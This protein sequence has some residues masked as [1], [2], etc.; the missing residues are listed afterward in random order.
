MTAFVGGATTALAD[1]TTTPTLTGEGLAGVVPALKN[2]QLTPDAAPWRLQA[3]TRVV[4]VEGDSVDLSAEAA[5]F[6]RDLDE[7]SELLTAPPQV[8]T[9]AAGTHAATDI[10]LKSGAVAGTDKADAYQ[11]Q[12]DASGVSITGADKHAVFLGT[13]TVLQSIISAGGLQAATVTDWP[14]YATRSLHVDA[15]RKYFSPQWFKDQ[16]KRMSLLKLTEL[17]YHFS[18][19]EGFRLQTEMYP[20]V[21]SEE[22][23]T[24]AELAEILAVAREYHI[25]VIPAMDI[26]GHMGKVLEAHPEW[27]AGNDN[28]GRRVLDYSKPEV[29]KF[30]TDLIDEFAPLFPTDK[31]HIGGDEVFDPDRLASLGRSFP[32]LQAYATENVG[33][34]ASVMD[35]YMHYLSTV[36]S[37]LNNNGKSRVRAW[38]DALYVGDQ[39]SL[40]ADVEVTYWTKWH[41]TMPSVAKLVEKGHKLINYHDGFFYYV[42]PRCPTCAYNQRVPASAIYDNWLPVNFSGNQTAPADSVLGSSYAIWADKPDLETEE[43]IANGIRLPL[44]AMAERVYAGEQSQVPYSVWEHRINVIDG[45]ASGLPPAPPVD[46]SIPVEN[47]S[48]TATS[49]ESA[50]EDGRARNVLD[51]RTNTIWHTKW[52]GTRDSL[53]QSLIF[54]LNSSYDLTGLRYTPRQDLASDPSNSMIREYRIYVSADGQTWGEP[55]ATGQFPRGAA[56]QE[57]PFPKTTGRFV[58]FEAIS[59]QV[60]TSHASAAE[61]RLYGEKAAAPEPPAPEAKVQLN[62]TASPA[63]TERLTGGQQVVY[64]VRVVNAGTQPQQLQVVGGHGQGKF[65]VTD[66]EATL[67]GEGASGEAA[68]DDNAGSWT[69]TLPAGGQL[70]LEI[71]GNVKADATGELQ[72]ATVVS[73]G[74]TQLADSTLTHQIQTAGPEPAPDSMPEVTLTSQPA[75]GTEIAPGQTVVYQL[76]AHN[77]TNKE[78]QVAVGGLFDIE[79]LSLKSVNAHLL[80]SEGA[81]PTPLTFDRANE[82]ASWRGAIPAGAVLT[83]QFTAEVRADGAGQAEAVF[84]VL[85]ANLADAFSQQVL[86]PI[87]AAPTPTPTAT[88]TPTETPAPTPTPTAAPL[89]VVRVAGANRVDT[90][91]KVMQAGD[92]S[93]AAVLSTGASFADAMAAGPLAGAL[94]APV[95][96]TMGPSLEP[97]LLSALKA[98][99]VRKVYVVGGPGAVS[100][101]K[102]AQLRA[103]GIEVHRIAGRDRFRTAVAVA[104]ET[105]RLTGAPAR[106][107]LADGM[108]YADALTTGVAAA[109]NKGVLILTN[110]DKLP[111]VSE[112]FLMDHLSAATVAV[113]GN[114]IA[115][116][117]SI[118]LISGVT[119]ETIAGRSRYAT[120]AELADKHLPQAKM[121]VVVS[122]QNYADALAGAALAVNS[123][124]MLLLTATN[125]VPAPTEELLRARPAVED[126]AV[127]GGPGTI[128]PEVDKALRELVR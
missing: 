81:A 45:K 80:A 97:N 100:E 114:A 117:K 36:D 18:E 26:P 71:S 86:H 59:A 39:A 108:D 69:G 90:A 21:V 63:T 119:M 66:A 38:N 123:D 73:S 101:A 74:D 82:S 23:I 112:K 3:A 68:N 65:V 32:S 49:E 103:A 41:R 92:F 13:R 96:L 110:R 98:E 19:N 120:A 113:G 22:H 9:L 43:V 79:Q 33:A 104:E 8:V 107:Y 17:Q 58:K 75:A 115:A 116:G 11:L 5:T 54:E 29:R 40:P 60:G 14:D 51:G 87:K 85:G 24:K 76:R 78:Q 46:T 77:T 16:I 50:M 48:V 72:F 53:P 124:G 106:V 52:S 83:A 122:G 31:W 10:V 126:V 67:Q 47:M 55:V 89:E 102:V 57:V 93:D 34:G 4:L 56:V 125:R 95:L 37:Y 12:V 27:R 127:L 118:G 20:E 88:P 70:V 15:A 99:S 105:I 2:V 94:R 6:A 84:I 121:A 35:G 64:T 30:V 25:E 91:I 7:K 42:L 111:Q 61:V 128:S 28:V 1:E 44:A 109:K 62:V